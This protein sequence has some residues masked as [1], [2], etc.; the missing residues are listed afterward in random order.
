MCACDN[1]HDNLYRRG[2]KATNMH[3]GDFNVS[4]CFSKTGDFICLYKEKIHLK[5]KK[6]NTK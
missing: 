3:T 6:K 4:V 1:T 5:K 2:E